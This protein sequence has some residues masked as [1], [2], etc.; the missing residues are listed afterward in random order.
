MVSQILP[1]SGDEATAQ[2]LRSEA[3]SGVESTQKAVLISG[4]HEPGCDLDQNS[5][6]GITN[7]YEQDL[8]RFEFKKLYNI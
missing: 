7:Y 4:S 3:T 6:S 8:E 5:I 1:K 2:D